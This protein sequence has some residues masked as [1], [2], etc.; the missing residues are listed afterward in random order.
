[1]TSFSR[2]RRWAGSARAMNQQNREGRPKY[3]RTMAPG[4]AVPDSSGGR[5]LLLAHHPHSD[6]NSRSVLHSESRSR[7]GTPPGVRR[8][9][10]ARRASR[11][12][13]ANGRSQSPPVATN[14]SQIACTPESRADRF[15]LRCECSNSPSVSATGSSSPVY[16]VLGGG[17]FDSTPSSRTSAVGVPSE[18]QRALC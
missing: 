1:M 17:S 4:R 7:N 2:I 14:M 9:R 10:P 6:P 3:P 16:G 13:G 8:C 5:C 11:P 12:I 15:P 18:N